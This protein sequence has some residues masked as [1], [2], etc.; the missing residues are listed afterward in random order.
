MSASI[1]IAVYPEDGLTADDILKN[2]DN[3]M[4]AAKHAG[5][6][7]WKFYE[8]SMLMRA[9]ETMVLTNNLRHAIDRNELSLHYQP[10]VDALGRIVSFEALLRWHSWKFGNVSPERF[11]SLAEQSGL[12]LPIGQ[13]VLQEACQFAARLAEMGWS[14][15]KVSA[16]VSP[17]QLADVNFETIVHEAIAIAGIEPSQLVIE[18]TESG[19]LGSV[20]DSIEKLERLRQ[21]GIGAS[22]DDFGTGFSSLT[23]LQ[24][25]PVQE[26]KIDRSFIESILEVPI[27]KTLVRSIVDMAH[28]L[29]LRVVAEGVETREQWDFLISC[30]CDLAQGYLF[31]RPLPEN[32]AL[33]KL[34][35]N[36]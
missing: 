25:L 8:A 33:Q 29:S 28:A 5:K 17:R 7:C 34:Q 3:A 4:Y 6:N 1:G 11:I 14:D 21:L 18:I 13:W 10:Q 9:Y 35:S 30:Q 27:R 22:L 19:L 23:Y 26:L 32:E 16:N 20:E 24:Q 15:C 12:I 31:S 2:A 36:S